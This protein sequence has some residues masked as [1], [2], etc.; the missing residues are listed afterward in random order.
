MALAET[1][2]LVV[3]LDLVVQAV[4]LE[5]LVRLETSPLVDPAALVKL[6]KPVKTWEAILQMVTVEMT[7]VAPSVVTSGRK[8]TTSR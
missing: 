6:A 1:L 7:E 4:T 8:A 5:L 2:G 3:K